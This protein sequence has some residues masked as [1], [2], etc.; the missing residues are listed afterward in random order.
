MIARFMKTVLLTS[1]LFRRESDL[2]LP[3][4]SAVDF[5]RIHP[6]R[7][8]FLD[9]SDA[10]LP[11]GA[12]VTSAEFLQTVAA[13]TLLLSGDFRASEPGSATCTY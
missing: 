12:Q 6:K 10:A 8:R 13:G 2:D 7:N 4:V 11:A 9:T 5:W 3:T 1:E